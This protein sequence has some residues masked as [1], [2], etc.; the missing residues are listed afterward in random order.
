MTG[1]PVTIPSGLDHHRERTL[2]HREDLDA[3]KEE[4]HT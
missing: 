2:P 1:T 3:C 4:S